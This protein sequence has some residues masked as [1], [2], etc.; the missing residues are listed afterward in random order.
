MN[1]WMALSGLG[2]GI[3]VGMTGMGGGALMTPILVLFFGVSPLAAVSNDL[4]TSAVMKPVG[5][6]VHLRR[7]TVNRRLV[8]WLM[9]GSVP[10]AFAGVLIA[11]AL[12]QTG[13]VEHVIETALGVALLVAATSMGAKAYLQLRER[14]TGGMMS[15]D[16]TSIRIKP[17]PTV[18][19]GILGGV[20]VG[21]TS[22]GSGSLM[23]VALLLLYPTLTAGS[24]VGTDLAQAVPL[25][26]SAAIAHIIF[27]DF[28]LGVTGSL[29]LGSLPGVYLGARFSS[30][31]SGGLVR[32]ALMLVLLASGLQ[33]LD[34][35]VTLT[36]VLVLS[37]LVL[38]PL[39]WM[40]AR[41]R[42]GLPALA[43]YETRT[44]KEPQD[45][46]SH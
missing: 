6:A 32:R 45:A 20:V 11:R 36:A 25:V 8:Y 1:W 40:W 19:I 23:I 27:G 39:T 26:M 21:M 13:D 38:G 28:E 15:G 44:V 31:V 29:L 16:A 34:V 46:V 35:S 14:T 33:M 10:S 41:R 7:G 5:A 24:L 3:V 12:G 17:A 42:H 30:R 9:A 22:V 43:R 18:L 37:A 2:V 4:V